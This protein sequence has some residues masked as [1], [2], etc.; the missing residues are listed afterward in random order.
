MLHKNVG[1][2]GEEGSKTVWGASE[3]LT[4]RKGGGGHRTFLAID[5]LKG[6]V[7]HFH[8]LKVGA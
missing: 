6:G 1:I 8:P 3:V 4:L 5:L 2:A 7:K